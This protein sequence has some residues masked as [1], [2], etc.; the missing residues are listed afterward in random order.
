MAFSKKYFLVE[1]YFITKCNI[2]HRR[3]WKT[4]SSYRTYLSTYRLLGISRKDT[5]MPSNPNLNHRSMKSFNINYRICMKYQKDYLRPR[6]S[7]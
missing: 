7:S 1:K 4:F 5:Q 6:N 2:K 3:T